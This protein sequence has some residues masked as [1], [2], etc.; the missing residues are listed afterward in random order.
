MNAITKIVLFLTI[1]LGCVTTAMAESKNVTMQVGETQTLYLPSSVT[2]KTLRS[3]TFY[4]NEISYVQ[5]LSYTNYSVKVKAIKAFSSPIIV[6]C[7][8]YYLINNG[9]YT[10]QAKGYYDFNITIGESGGNTI[11][12]IRIT[13]PFS[14]KAIE[15]DE[16]VKLEPTVLPSNAEYML[17]W[18]IN[19]TSVATVDQQGNLTGKSEGAADLKVTTDNGVYAM[20]RVVVSKPSPRSVS[21]SPTKLELTEGDFRYLDAIVYPS[22]ASKTVTWTTS[23]SSVATVSRS[24]K[25]TTISEGSCTITAKTSNNRSASA[26]VKVLPKEVE[27]TSISLSQESVEIEEDAEFQL[28]ASVFPTNANTR[29]TWR[30]S[31][32]AIATIL[33]GAIKGVSSG[34]CSVTATTDNGLFATASVVVKA[35]EILPQSVVLSSTSLVME[36]G[37]LSSLNVNVMPEN[38]T[39]ELT[40]NTTNPEVAIVTHGEVTAIGA[41]ECV[42]TASTQNGLMTSCIVTVVKPIVQ[43][44]SISITSTS[45]TLQVGEFSDLTVE[46]H[47]L[48]AEYE[49][50]WMSSDE[51]V[52][53]VSDSG[54]V[55]AISQGSCII[56]VATQ[57]GLKAICK[58]SVGTDGPIVNP[59]I[60]WCG[61]YKM[62]ATVDDTGLSG[63]QYPTEFQMIIDKDED[64]QYYI[65]SFIGFNCVKSYPYTGLRLKVKSETEATIDLDYNDNAGSWTIDGEYINGIHSLSSD[66]EYSYSNQGEIVLTKTDEFQISISQFYVYYFGQSSDYEHIQDA[67][68]TNCRGLTDSTTGISQARLDEDLDERM[69]VYTL[70]GQHIYSGLIKNVPELEHG[71]YIVRQRGKTYKILK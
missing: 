49:L 67:Y 33:D 56:I 69:E 8:Y 18:S 63:Y 62:N 10:Y 70:N 19:D 25:V 32:N 22:S 16:T 31:D 54:S 20:L 4:S 17:T 12:P 40:W 71:L 29:I 60:D 28:S 21:V 48:D 53:T 46:V 26:T 47:P 43:P 13:F 7:D 35:K 15:V 11:A 58:V 30:S 2:S 66:S 59:K 51:N 50:L 55:K 3:V 44:E 5:V 52:A 61:T 65:T 23:N 68:Y 37:E 42:I 24:G 14:V 38:A 64:N 45:I 9:G 6:R 57:N 34:K 41:G 27:P 1:L 36:V 39:Y